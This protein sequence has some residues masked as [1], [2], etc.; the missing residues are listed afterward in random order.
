M[1]L[2]T[3]NSLSQKRPPFNFLNNSVKNQQILIFFCIQHPEK[4]ILCHLLYENYSDFM[5]LRIWEISESRWNKNAHLTY[6]L[7]PHY[8]GNTKSDFSQDS[9]VIS[10][11]QLN[12]QN[13]FKHFRNSHCWITTS[14]HY[15]RVFKVHRE[16]H[17]VCICHYLI[18]SSTMHC[19]NGPSLNQCWCNYG[20]MRPLCTFI[21]YIGY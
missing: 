2:Q 7:L 20:R 13:K 19:W 18:S 21:C 3:L 5:G 9:T 14:L 8:L 17:W 1:N 4:K 10:I 6:I 12:F 15:K 16:K 11:K